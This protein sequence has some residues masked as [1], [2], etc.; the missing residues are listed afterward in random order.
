MLTNLGV[1][2]ASEATTPLVV[3][4][5]LLFF[6]QSDHFRSRCAFGQITTVCIVH[7]WGSCHRATVPKHELVEPRVALTW[8]HLQMRLDSHTSYF[9]SPGP[10]HDRSWSLLALL[11]HQVKP[12]LSAAL[13]DWTHRCR[14]SIVTCI[15]THQQLLPALT[16]WLR[17]TPNAT[18]R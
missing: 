11:F 12:L 9:G 7:Q 17:N 13:L 8:R 18:C 6:L 4:P 5:L 3:I 14:R 1:S 10:W 2:I 15:H 16:W